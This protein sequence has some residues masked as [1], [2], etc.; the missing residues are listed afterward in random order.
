MTASA[1]LWEDYLCNRSESLMS[2][3][4]VSGSGTSGVQQMIGSIRSGV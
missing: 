3:V 1:D 2:R 4:F